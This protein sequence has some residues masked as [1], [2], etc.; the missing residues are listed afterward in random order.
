MN[1]GIS[2]F[3]YISNIKNGSI[4]A[5]EFVSKTLDHIQRVE[6][7]LH[8]F[9]SLNR[10]SLE[11]ARSIDN[12]IKSG[13]KL[14]IGFFNTGAYQDTLSGYGGIKHCLLPSPPH[15]LID[16][17]KKRRIYLQGFCRRTN[18]G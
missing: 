13:E 15:I 18:F 10:D 9:I 14:F 11:H 17:K 8:A 5:E 12:K 4:T 7:K 3:E 1:L 6:P 2:A 16:E